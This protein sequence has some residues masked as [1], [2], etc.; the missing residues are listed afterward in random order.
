[1]IRSTFLPLAQPH[2]SDEELAAVAEVVG[3]GWLT[4][5]PKVHE[6]EQKFADYLKLD[7]P[8]HVTALNSCSSAMFLVLKALG[9]GPGDEVIIPTW[10][11]AATGQIVEWAGAVPIL[12]DVE[13][14]SLGID[15]G[16]AEKLITPHTKAIIPVHIGGYPCNMSGILKLAE[17]YSLKTIED[18]AHAI[19]TRYNG[20][21]I[22]NFSDA[23]C[24][25]FYA[26]KN[27]AMGEGGAVASKN[28]QLIKKIE[29]IAYFGINKDAYKRYKKSGTWRYDI[30][31]LGYKCNLDSMHA[32]L[33]LVQLKKIESLNHRRRSIAKTYKSQLDKS[34]TYTE[35]SDHHYHTFHLF[36]IILPEKI[37]RDNFI[38]QLKKVNIGSSVHFIPLHRHSYFKDRFTDEE[39][40]NANAIYERILSIPMFP[41]MTNEDVGYVIDN[42]NTMVRRM[43]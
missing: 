18:A 10:T 23:T 41:S 14:L 29:K 6:F 24:F 12:C 15:V 39:F 2:I 28:D 27:L 16:K 20:I 30:E 42:I 34:I 22:G 25:S 35:N 36:Q 31:E 37:N 13:G 26:T 4:T 7:S 17:K 43:T 40:P 32:A 9:I 1:M 33:G 19:G 8:I 11:F 38:R 21:K 3:S 5:G